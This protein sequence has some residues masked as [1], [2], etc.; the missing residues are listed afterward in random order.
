MEEGD[1][2]TWVEL[3]NAA[4]PQLPITAEGVR[5]GIEHEQTL[6][7]FLGCLDDRP[8]GAALCLEQGDMRH[9]DVAVAFFGVRPDE[10]RR[11]VGS[12]LYGAVSEHARALGKAQLQVDVWEDELDGRH[13]LEPRGFVEVER[14]ARVRLELDGTRLPDAPIPPGV[15]IVPFER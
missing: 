1:V 8:V 3:C 12:A 7:H 5:R 9:T 14:F 11:G 15:E 13:F 6:A 4:D 2:E 10:R